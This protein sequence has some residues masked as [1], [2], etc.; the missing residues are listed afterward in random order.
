MWWVYIIRCKD[1]S[2][3]TGIARDVN[4][5]LAVHEKGRG[6]R[7]TRGRGPLQLWWHEG[8]L[9]HQEALSEERRVKRLSHQKKESMGGLS[10]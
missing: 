7:Y 3:Y 6:A 2:F 5:R 1:G 8:P 10:S 9:T 4:R